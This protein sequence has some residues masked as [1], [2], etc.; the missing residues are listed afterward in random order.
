M[1][2]RLLMGGEDSKSGIGSTST[3][4]KKRQAWRME[5]TIS[6]HARNEPDKWKLTVRANCYE[7]AVRYPDARHTLF[8]EIYHAQEFGMDNQA[9]DP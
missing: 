5:W 8:L 7:V 4:H 1:P 2:R 9:M 6:C 3:N